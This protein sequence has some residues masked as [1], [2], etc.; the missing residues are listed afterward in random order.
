MVAFRAGVP[1]APPSIVAE[2]PAMKSLFRLVGR[3]APSTVPVL[4]R[5]ETGSGKEVVARGIHE[6]SGRSGAFVPVNC[7]ALPGALIESELFG[8]ARGSFTGA[9]R[10]H[11]GVFAQADGGTL[12]LDEIGELPLDVQAKLLRVLDDGVVRPV[13]ASVGARVDA[14][15]VAATHRDLA[16]A[17]E[18]G[19]F[20][21]DL[22]Y[23][24]AVVVLEVPP[25]RER[26]EDIPA[27]VEKFVAE[28][29]RGGRA[30]IVTD[31]VMAFLLVRRWPGN[32]RQLRAAVH[33]AVLLGDAVLVP[34]DFG[35]PPEVFRSV[36]EAHSP[37]KDGRTWSEVEREVLLQAVERHGS[38]RAA[39]RA[40]GRPKS[41]VADH[42]RRL[43]GP[44][45]GIAGRR[46]AGAEARVAVQREVVHARAARG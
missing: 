45:P 7:S 20:R 36:D 46:T 40:L 16:A 42:V 35:L 37:T 27:L 21:E 28:A 9:D 38:I 19:H 43:L 29:S 31:E 44:R 26:P 12:L 13:G 1:M 22:Y 34:E 25:L 2:S 39:A 10:A 33:R 17:V 18:Q 23:R 6:R 11:A 5:G 3:V 14:R 4:V 41:T 15:V 8:H 30:P 32:A 24:L